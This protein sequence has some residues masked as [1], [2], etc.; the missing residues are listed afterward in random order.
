M[1]KKEDTPKAINLIVPELVT[2][3][4]NKTVLIPVK[5]QNTWN[6]SLKGITLN[7]TTNTSQV[8]LRFSQDYFEELAVGEQKE[9]IL[10]VDNY[11]IGENY[12][13]QINANVTEPKASDSAL[14]LLNTIE[15]SQSGEDV[16]IKVT[17]A[18]DLLNENPECLELNELL[19]KAKEDLDKGNTVE[20]SK[21]VDGVINGCKY[22]VSISK[23]TEQKPE[24]IINRLWKRENLKFLLVFA[25]I[26]LILVLT[27]LLVNKKKVVVA[28]NKEA[29]AKKAEEE[30]V[31]PY[32]G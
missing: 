7:A 6:S 18:Q 25:G 32:W 20:A 5:V 12:E 2:I 16:E 23:K 17:F 11:R 3:Y 14:V 29:E 10:F 22:L 19:A 28:K 1:Q 31:K 27:V 30:Q 24:T 15:Q 13:I 21:M 4:E 26:A 8:K 9:L